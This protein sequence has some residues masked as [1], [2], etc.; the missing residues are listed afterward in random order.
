M[1]M[2]RVPWSPSETS[3]AGY[4][5]REN[6]NPTFFP[7]RGAEVVYRKH[8]GAA[9]QVIGQMGALHPEVLAFYE[10]PFVASSLELDIEAFLLD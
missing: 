7:G 1:K 3:E 2:L 8:K 4:W 10:L 5:I 9:S 6:N